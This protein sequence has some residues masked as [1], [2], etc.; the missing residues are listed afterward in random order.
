VISLEWRR[1]AGSIYSQADIIILEEGLV[2]L[3]QG[4]GTCIEGNYVL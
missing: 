2:P 3:R 4:N 1:V